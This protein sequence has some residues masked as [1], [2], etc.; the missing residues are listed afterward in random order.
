MGFEESVRSVIGQVNY[1]SNKRSELEKSMRESPES[2]GV[3]N[4][5]N[6]RDHTR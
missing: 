1:S 4:H 5:K 2:P 3:Y 6:G